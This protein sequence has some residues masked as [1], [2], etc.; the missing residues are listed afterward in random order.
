MLIEGK[1]HGLLPIVC[2]QPEFCSCHF[3]KKAK[4]DLED[5]RHLYVTFM[6][7]KVFDGAVFVW[8]S[9]L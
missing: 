7:L 3:S 2:I 6:V 9:A 4:S 8:K 5:W 1:T